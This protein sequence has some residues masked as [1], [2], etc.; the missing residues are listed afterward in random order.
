MSPAARTAGTPTRTARTTASTEPT[1]GWARTARSRP[2][3]SW[4][5]GARTARTRAFATRPARTFSQV[6]LWTASEMIPCVLASTAGRA[7]W[8][9]LVKGQFSIAVLIER[10]ERGG[11]IGDLFG[12]QLAVVVGVQSFHQRV[13]RRPVPPPAAAPFPIAVGRTLTIAFVIPAGR[14]LGGLRNDHG[15]S[16]RTQHTNDQERA[17]HFVSPRSD[18][19]AALAGK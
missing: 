4:T 11:R 10:F 9:Q 19:P 12:R 18:L 2:I 17:T 16:Q 8:V 1:L 5:T 6:F 3:S 14:P 15:R 13:A 7:V